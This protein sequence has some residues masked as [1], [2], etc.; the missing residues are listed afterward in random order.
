MWIFNAFGMLG[1]LVAILSHSAVLIYSHPSRFIQ[2]RH[3]SEFRF[4]SANLN[5]SHMKLIGSL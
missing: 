5:Q 1:T 2:H 3:N 4:V